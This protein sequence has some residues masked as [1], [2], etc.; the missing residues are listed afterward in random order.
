[1]QR[2]LFAFMAL[3]SLLA[4]NLRPAQAQNPAP[5]E[6]TGI[7]GLALAPPA[8]ETASGG[9]TVTLAKDDTKDNLRVNG[10]KLILEGHVKN[11][12]LAI[13]SDVTIKPGAKVGGHLVVIG[14]H[15][16]DQ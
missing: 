6:G 10:E 5:P 15:V 14:G 12:V 7:E 13:N 9:R 3:A 11:D 16:D 2:I 8:E 4:I 1:M